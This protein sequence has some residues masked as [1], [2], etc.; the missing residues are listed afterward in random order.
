MSHALIQKEENIH[1]AFKMMDKDQSGT[2][3]KE[4]LKK[5]SSRKN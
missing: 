2:I 4:E 5:V 1:M 3:S